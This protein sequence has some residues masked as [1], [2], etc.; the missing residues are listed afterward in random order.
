MSKEVR[1][2]LCTLW[3]LTFK[4]GALIALMAEDGEDWKE[5]AKA[6]PSEASSSAPSSDAS[7]GGSAPAAQP[8]GGN[9]PGTSVNMPSLS[10]TMTEG[11]IV[12][13]CV[14]VSFK[15]D[16]DISRPSTKTD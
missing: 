8:T 14:K 7:S 6:G 2:T 9:T 4:V 3:F 12:K 13:W 11:T 15:I 16:E 5:V 1:S 10:P